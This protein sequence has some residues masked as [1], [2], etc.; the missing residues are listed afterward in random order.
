MPEFCDTLRGRWKSPD[1]P[2]SKADMK[3]L[4]LERIILFVALL[5][6]AVNVHAADEDVA[7]IRRLDESRRML[8]SGRSQDALKQA[9]MVV[10]FYDSKYGK[11]PRKV[12]CAR[13]KPESLYYLLHAAK[14]E[15]NAIV[16]NSAWADAHF[17]KGYILLDLQRTKEGRSSLE[18]ALELSPNNAQYLNEMAHILQSEKQWA[19]SQ[20]LFTRAEEFARTYSPEESK[21]SELTRALRGQGYNLVELGKLKEAER[22]YL[23]CVGLDPQDKKSA[24]EL[25]WIAAQKKTSNPR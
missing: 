8:E 7:Q 4:R 11:E 6:G 3:N 14:D 5:F 17:I 9:E 20:E 2:Q 16:V 15:T 25:K 1:D 18:R 13:T 23:E 21:T 22:K 12:Y 10:A 19:K 24:A